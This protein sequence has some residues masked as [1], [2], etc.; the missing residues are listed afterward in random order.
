M[1]QELADQVV[2]TRRNLNMAQRA[3]E[4]AKTPQQVVERADEY[5]AAEEDHRK[6]LAA[7]R[8]DMRS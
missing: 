4:L 3:M 8:K 6:A 2:T 5:V 1:K 7:A